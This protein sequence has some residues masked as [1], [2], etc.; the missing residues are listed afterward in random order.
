MRT[1]KES[2]SWTVHEDLDLHCPL[3]VCL[4]DLLSVLFLMHAC[5]YAQGCKPDNTTCHSAGCQWTSLTRV[6]S[7]MLPTYVKSC[8][9]LDTSHAVSRVYLTLVFVLC[10]KLRNC[11]P[12]KFSSRVSSRCFCV[13]A[14]NLRAKLTIIAYCS[15]GV[16]CK[17]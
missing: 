16:H 7:F 10:C 17:L 1:Q 5:V 14:V 3:V 4:S 11:V 9:C 2:C 15:S 13:S 6:C 12:A 8:L